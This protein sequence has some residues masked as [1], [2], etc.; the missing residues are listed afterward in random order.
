MATLDNFFDWVEYCLH[1]VNVYNNKYPA[2]KKL[3]LHLPTNN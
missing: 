2:E 3:R 1:K